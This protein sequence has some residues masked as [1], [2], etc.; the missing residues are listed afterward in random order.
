MLSATLVLFQ[1]FPKTSSSTFSCSSSLCSFFSVL[2]PSTQICPRTR[3]GLIAL[4]RVCVLPGH[5][6]CLH[7]AHRPEHSENSPSH[8]PSAVTKNTTK[9]K[10]ISEAL[11]KK[12]SVEAPLGYTPGSHKGNAWLL[13]T[14]KPLQST[15]WPC[16]GRQALP[17]SNLS[18]QLHSRQKASRPGKTTA[19]DH[20]CPGA[21]VHIWSH[22]MRTDKPGVVRE[23]QILQGTAVLWRT[24]FL[25]A[26]PSV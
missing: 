1:N 4:L 6:F 23:W 25:K 9:Q 22:K 10:T 21:R 24:G 19:T 3:T 16:Q 20:L 13:E 11:R 8:T 18:P 5:V 2:L 12:G 7:G 15:V 26:D 14:L 17:K